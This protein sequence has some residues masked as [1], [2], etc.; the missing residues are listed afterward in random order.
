MDGRVE[1]DDE[2]TGMPGISQ[3]HQDKQWC[4]RQQPRL[5]PWSP[6]PALSLYIA[7]V[8]RVAYSPFSLP[9]DP[10]PAADMLRMHTTNGSSAGLDRVVMSFKAMPAVLQ[11]HSQSFRG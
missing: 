3:A 9:P 5:G 11:E 10:L 7:P 1:V 4:S 6:A 8:K 2:G